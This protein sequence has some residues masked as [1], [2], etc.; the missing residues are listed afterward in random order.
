[1]DYIIP[2][3]RMRDV[4]R[5]YDKCTVG[6]IITDGEGTIIWGNETYSQI[7]GF[8]VRQYFGMPVGSISQHEKVEPPESG[9]LLH[10]VRATKAPCNAVVKYNTSDY[11]ITTATPLLDETREDRP[12]QFIL[13]NMI[14]CTEAMRVQEELESSQAKILSLE[15]QLQEL[16]F[17]KILG[18]EII[19]RDRRM[20]Q[21]YKMAL[22][23]SSV[24]VPIMILGESGAGKDVLAKFIHN[25]GDRREKNFIHVNLGAI[26]KALFESELFGYAPGAF[27]GAAR[28]GKEGLIQLADG[29]TLFLDE[30]GELP[31]DIQAKLLQVTQDRV[32]R[33]IGSARA[34]P[35]DIRIICATNRNVGE[36]V[37]RG[38]FRLD[39][40]Y[41]L[42]VAEISIPPLRER[43][44]EIGPLVQH[45]LATFNEKYHT[46][47]TIEP[48]AMQYLRKYAWPGNVRELC[49]VVES[50]V[51]IS[52]ENVIRPED[53]PHEIYPLAPVNSPEPEAGQSLD[54]K[55]AVAET[56]IRLIRQALQEN[57]NAL[58]A[59][60][61]LGI[62]SSTLSKKR[63]KYGL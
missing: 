41:R 63:K 15:S 9:L 46:R 24:S 43:P 8:D 2:H 22:Q 20:E 61:A 58:Q 59:A 11:V 25:V 27:T 42:N 62:D 6:I 7:A 26:P 55:Q 28:G 13:Y 4:A 14:N 1:M 38:E 32:V 54:L 21:I 31:L 17:H 10:T 53:L 33:R 51:I 57:P 29:G 34:T 50:L 40:Y 12:I 18:H 23:L 19:V 45:F 60:A 49:H 16:R 5:I 56:E 44:E 37:R 39:L 48:V 36:M 3:I 35:V 52:P 30:V 47:K